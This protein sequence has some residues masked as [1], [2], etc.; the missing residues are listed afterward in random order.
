MKLVEPL[1]GKD[2]CLFVDN[3]YMSLSLLLDLLY[4]G[5]YCAGTIQQ[6]SMTEARQNTCHW[7]F[8]VCNNGKH[9]WVFLLKKVWYMACYLQFLIELLGGCQSPYL[10]LLKM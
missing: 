9:T 5:T 8:P 7:F 3:F 2:H 10:Q 1:Q 4:L 6:L